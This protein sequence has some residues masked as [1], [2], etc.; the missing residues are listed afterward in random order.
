VTEPQ[1][2]RGRSLSA[3]QKARIGGI[4]AIVVVTVALVADNRQ[5]VAVG[6]VFGES[7]VSLVVLIVVTWILGIAIGWLG[8]RARRRDD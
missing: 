5:R 1:Q 8:A 6:Y 4:A 7:R 2:D 3:R